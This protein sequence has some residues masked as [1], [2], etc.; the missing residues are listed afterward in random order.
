METRQSTYGADGRPWLAVGPVG[1]G[2]HRLGGFNPPVL[3]VLDWPTAMASLEAKYLEIITG[4]QR[5]LSSD[6]ARGVLWL[7]SIPYVCVI[8]CRNAYYD[9]IKRSVRRVDRPVISVGNLTVGGTGKT[10]VASRI[11]N[12]LQKQGHDVALLLRGYKGR[13][14]QF[15][16]EHLDQAATTW[17]KESDEAMVLR[18]RCPGAK[19]IVDPDRVAAARR[20]I[21]GGADVLILDDGFQH[22]RI[23]RDLDVVLIDATAP[24]GHGYPLPRGLLRE[25]T[26]SLRRADLVVLTHSDQIHET[27]KTLLL[28][29]L[30]R[31]SGDKPVLEAVHRIIGFTD[32]K[33][34]TVTV[35]DRS[36]MQAVLFA[37]IANFESFTR[38]VKQ[39]GAKV[40]AAYQYPDHHDYSTEEIAG[41]ADLAAN[42]EANV[43][44]TTEKDAVKLVGRWDDQGCRLLVPVLDIEFLGEGDKILAE[45]I[46]GCVRTVGSRARAAS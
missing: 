9:W 5:G 24:F 18:R 2:A 19:V 10:P 31:A 26:R 32:I 35:E 1:A 12:I 17:R 42:L 34:A 8:A 45:A 23:A 14:I 25:P 27:Q 41:L 40:L 46:E 39:L 29:S 21:D 13:T 36:V 33:G 15:D 28:R 16:D 22:R 37:G 30:R 11:A 3:C 44:L 4:R 6:L 20:A 43:L 7:L 38:S